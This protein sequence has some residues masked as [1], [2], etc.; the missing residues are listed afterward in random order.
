[1][2]WFCVLLLPLLL[3]AEDARLSIDS[4]RPVISAAEILARQYRISVSAEDPV[5]M[6]TA[7]QRV[8]LAPPD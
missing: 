8:Q 4:D 1:M 2:R 7:L 6:D 5:Y 3:Q